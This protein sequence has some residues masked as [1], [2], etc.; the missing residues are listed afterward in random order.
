M[1]GILDW[2][3]NDLKTFPFFFF[4]VNSPALH[5]NQEG[6]CIIVGMCAH[7]GVVPP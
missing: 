1:E 4:V 2:S 7:F 5:I 3:L 6:G